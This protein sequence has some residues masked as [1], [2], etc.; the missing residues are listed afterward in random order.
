MQ[1]LAAR[2]KPT[3]TKDKRCEGGRKTDRE[4]ELDVFQDA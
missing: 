3:H 1:A 4:R 2:V